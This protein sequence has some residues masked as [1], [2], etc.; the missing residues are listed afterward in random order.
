M[1]GT[2]AAEL[3]TGLGLNL[4]PGLIYAGL[5]GATKWP[6]GKPSKNTLWGRIAGMHLGRKHKF[7]TFRHTL[8][9]ILANSERRSTIDEDRLTTW[10]HE[11]LRVITVTHQDADTLGRLE[12]DVLAS[13]DTPLNLDKVPASPIRSRITSLRKLYA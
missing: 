13:L 9:S 8:G 10:M 11:H 12:W 2:G 4:E 6:S 1:D 3:S 7:S 5:A